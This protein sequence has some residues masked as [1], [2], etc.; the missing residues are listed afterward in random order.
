MVKLIQEVLD[1][2]LDQH[3]DWLNSKP[4]GVRAKLNNVDLNGLTIKNRSLQFAEL[5]GTSFDKT[6]LINVNF[7]NSDLIKYGLKLLLSIMLSLVSAL[8]CL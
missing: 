1:S 5:R 2:I 4:G 7:N 3:L 6:T 8:Y